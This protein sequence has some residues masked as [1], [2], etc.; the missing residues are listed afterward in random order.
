MVTDE[1]YNELNYNI[2]EILINE[3]NDYGGITKVNMPFDIGNIFCSTSDTVSEIT[4]SLDKSNL[5]IQ[6]NNRPEPGNTSLTV[7]DKTF[8]LIL[9]LKF[10]L[11]IKQITEMRIGDIGV[12]ING[13]I[14]RNVYS[15]SSP[16]NSTTAPNSIYSLSLD[17][18]LIHI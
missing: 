5:R 9:N 15:L 6:S 1:E 2:F 4:L 18:S 14:L 8:D 13:V 16:S 12:S 7:T 17:L 11:N 10:G 3:V